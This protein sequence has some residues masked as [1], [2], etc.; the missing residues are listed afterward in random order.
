MIS[1]AEVSRS[2]Y[3]AWLFARFNGNGITY[4]ANTVD[5]FWRSFWAAVLVLPAYAILLILRDTGGN[6]GVGASTAILVHSISYVMGWI[7][8]PFLMYYVGLKFNRDQWYCRY[9]AAYNWAVV[10]QIAL[11]LIVSVITSSGIIS[12]NAGWTAV[13]LV[14]LFMLV[15][16]G[17]IAY[18]GFQA[19][20]PGAAA[21]VLIDFSLNII[22]E[23]WSAHLLNLQP[24][25]IG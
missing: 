2:I 17:F 21:I 6:Y 13:R 14:V 20:L 5:G 23:F 19:T 15:Y 25:A 11:L 9:I 8:F 3:G 7:A 4:F 12:Q 1:A 24:S 22:L 16:R 18:V 10:I